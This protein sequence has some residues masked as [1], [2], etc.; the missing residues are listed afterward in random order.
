MRCSFVS[1]LHLDPS[2]PD[3]LEAFRNFLRYE[4]AHCDELF[5]LG[6]LT[7]VWVGDDDDS[8]FAD[9]LRANLR[10]AG[11]QCHV[12]L[13]HG[14]RDFL[15]G[16]TFGNACGL[17]LIADPYVVERNNKRL[18]L[19]H[20]DS[21]CADDLAYQQTRAVLRSRTWQDNVLGR[22]LADRRALA[23]SMRS[24]SRATNANKAANIMDATEDAIAEALSTHRADI[25]VHGHT[26]RP[27][28]HTNAHGRV[29]RY[30][31]GDWER[32]GWV[33]RFEREFSLLRIP[34]GG[35]AES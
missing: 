14:N 10:L 27:G 28:I 22:S 15:I 8:P 4:S 16:P 12:Y 32:C 9:A 17:E 19:C 23:E 26:H 34:R 31:L 21:L 24:E 33:L 3:V 5:I 20:G 25:V 13:M 35:R 2:R 7:E 18:L 11:S 6:D 1:D 30:V 29:T